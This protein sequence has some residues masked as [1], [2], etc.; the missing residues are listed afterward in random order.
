MMIPEEE[1][2]KKPEGKQIGEAKNKKHHYK[3]R[4]R[5]QIDF[6]PLLLRPNNTQCKNL[7]RKG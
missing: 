2:K 5:R 6:S 4:D 7:I 1:K 3:N